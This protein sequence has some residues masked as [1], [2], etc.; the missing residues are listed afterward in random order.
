MS[1]NKYS[2]EFL[3]K[4]YRDMVKIRHFED[5]VKFLFLEGIMPGT[6]HQY[7]LD[8]KALDNRIIRVFGG[9]GTRR[10]STAAT[11]SASPA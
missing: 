5:R 9:G 2:P 7:R 1:T 8:G 10:R 3:V 11:C 6:I 4:L